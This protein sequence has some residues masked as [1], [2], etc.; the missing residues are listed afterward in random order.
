[1]LLFNE[2]ILTRYFG[3]TVFKMRRD[4]PLNVAMRSI[5]REYELVDRSVYGQHKHKVYHIYVTACHDF[6]SL[7]RDGEMLN[8]TKY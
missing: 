7:A 8:S 5:G 6:Y 4:V 1:M 2:N 3:L